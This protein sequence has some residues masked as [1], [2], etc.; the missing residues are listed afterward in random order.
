MISPSRLA[1]VGII[2][3]PYVTNGFDPRGWGGGSHEVVN[4]ITLVRFELTF[5]A[6]PTLLVT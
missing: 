6:F 3:G 1:V 5:S 4:D 2:A